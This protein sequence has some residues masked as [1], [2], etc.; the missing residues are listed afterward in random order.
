M[1]R[2]HLSKCRKLDHA[3]L[4]SLIHM[5]YKREFIFIIFEAH[6]E[7]HIERKRFALYFGH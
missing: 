1:K 3:I 5:Y 7:G 2:E 6:N 4:P